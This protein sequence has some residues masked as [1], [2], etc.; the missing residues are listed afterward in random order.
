MHEADRGFAFRNQQPVV[1]GVR[2]TARGE[3]TKPAHLAE[4]G[5]VS[6]ASTAIKGTRPVYFGVEFVDTPIIDG[7]VLG[8]GATVHGPAL[9][10]EAF[11]VVT[12]APGWTAR[13]G[14]HASYDLTP[15]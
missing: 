14:E 7:T 15:A 1:R 2:L 3:T 5:S 13:L 10:E 11:T 12:V 4:L 6:D 9:I 8:P